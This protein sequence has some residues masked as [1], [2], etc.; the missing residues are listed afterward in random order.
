MMKNI[1][2]YVLIFSFTRIFAQISFEASVSK[3]SLGI[4]ERLRIVFE[5]NENGDNFTPPNFKDFSIIGGPN[6]SV[7]NS[8][9]NGKRSFSKKITYF[10]SPKSKGNITIG[11]AIVKI[12]GEIYKTSPLK[13]EITEAVETSL[14]ENNPNYIVE[15]NIHLVAE[16]SKENPYLNESFTVVYKLYYSDEI[17][18]S[19]VNELDK[20]KFPDFWSHT[21]KIPRLEVKQGVY[22]GSSYR[23]VTWNKT[24]LYPQK[25]GKLDLDPLTLNVSVDVPTNRAD[26]FGNRVYQQVPKVITAGKRSVNVRELPEKDKPDKFNGAVGD[27]DLEVFLNKT[28]LKASE[29]LQA[30]IKVKGRGNLKL[31]NLPKLSVPNSL[32]VY[33]PEHKQSIKTDLKGM[34][35]SIEDIYTIV[36]QNK[37]KFPIPS[38]SFSYFN[39]DTEKYISLN[40]SENIID[41]LDSPNNDLNISSN[42]NFLVRKNPLI[43]DMPFSFIRLKSNFISVNEIKFW[44]TK[45]F[46]FV[47]IFPFL[48]LILFGII[49]WIYRKRGLNKSDNRSKLANILARRYLSSAKKRI[50]DKDLF[51][52][53]LERALHNYLKAKLNIETN[54]FNKEK[55]SELLVI[56]SIDKL[57]TENFVKLLEDCELARYSPSTL[58]RMKED[59]ENAIK[60]IALIDKQL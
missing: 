30:K 2:F 24:V 10:L 54:E 13:I 9:I 56:K 18:I 28:E 32:E 16:L 27:F 34:Q 20:P 59:F 46:Y 57:S 53:S 21:I 22:K 43:F 60:T 37:G 29:S 8:W 45:K 11:Q 33:D 6:Q 3:N 19:S 25:I 58:V 38:I 23:Y 15:N 39:P 31:F 7:S 12:N 49:T 51:Y 5:M 47:L 48:L 44:E 52:D 41:V 1:L 36:P 26:F 35:G 17:G 50:G 55:I 4:N 42:T 40:S 14:G